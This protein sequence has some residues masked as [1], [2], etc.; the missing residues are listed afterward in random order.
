MTLLLSAISFAA[1]L[2]IGLLVCLEWG[3]RWG[4][5]QLQRDPEGLRCHHGG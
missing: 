2:F 1:C 3:R 4:T 5:R